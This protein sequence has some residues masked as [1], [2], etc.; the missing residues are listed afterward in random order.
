MRQYTVEG[1]GLGWRNIHELQHVTIDKNGKHSSA[2]IL[3][4]PRGDNYWAKWAGLG[5]CS[6]VFRAKRLF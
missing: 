1:L 6:T 2:K 5:I 4:H 3:I